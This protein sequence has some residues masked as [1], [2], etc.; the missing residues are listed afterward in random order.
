MAIGVVKI[1]VKRRPEMRAPMMK[2]V[3]LVNSIN[4]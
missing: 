2:L 3:P 1:E 4:P